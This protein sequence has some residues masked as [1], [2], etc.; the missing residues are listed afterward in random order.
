[1]SDNVTHVYEVYIRTTPEK[2]WEA[3]TD[4]RFTRQYFF[5]ATVDSDWRPG[6]ALN[7]ALPDGRTPFFATI[8]AIDPPRRLV[9]SFR[10]NPEMDGSQDPP[11]RVTYEIEPL[12]PTCLLRLT[13]EHFAGESVVTK[14][15]HEGWQIIFSGLKTLLETGEPLKI[16]WPDEIVA[17]G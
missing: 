11:S 8:E 1:M 16:D 3:I 5:G 7:Y 17:T 10:S 2:L 4:T 12:G 6:A 14:G 13:H 9:H 15:T